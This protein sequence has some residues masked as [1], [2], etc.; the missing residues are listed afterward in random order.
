MKKI[1]LVSVFFLVV[2]LMNAQGNLQFSQV[3]LVDVTVAGN[4]VTVPAGKVWKLENVALASNNAYVQLQYSGSNF[5]LS[6]SSSNYNHFPFWLPGGNAVVITGSAAGKL[7]VIEF[8]VV[9]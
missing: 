4:A 1:L 7:S 8:N 6:N 9:P 2:H 3:L 5:F